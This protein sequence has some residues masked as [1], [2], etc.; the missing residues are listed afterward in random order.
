MRAATLLLVSFFVGCSP[1]L[2]GPEACNE[3]ADALQAAVSR[4]GGDGAAAHA[5]FILEVAGGDCDTITRVRDP[6]GL[7]GDWLPFL[8][9][10]DCSV[11][12][13]PDFAGGLPASCKAQLERSP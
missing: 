8:K 11:V 4:C 5:D 3:I 9:S 2:S 10:V 12:N 6:E 1:S 7:E 13:G